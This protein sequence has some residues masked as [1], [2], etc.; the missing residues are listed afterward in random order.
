MKRIISALTLATFFLGVTALAVNSTN[1]T[2]KPSLDLEG[3]SSIKKAKEV[4]VKK[5][6]TGTTANVGYLN[7]FA[8]SNGLP[9]FKDENGMET[10]L[11]AGMGSQWVGSIDYGYAANCD[12]NSTSASFVDFSE[13]TDCNTPTVTGSVSAPGTKI[14]AVVVPVD[15]V[16][17]RYVF[18]AR[19]QFRTGGGTDAC[20]YRF[21]DGTDSSL[22]QLGDPGA[23][24]G[25]I[26]ESGITFS[27]KGSKTVKI[28]AKSEGAADSCR[29]QSTLAAR[30]FS[31]DV[32]KMGGTGSAGAILNEWQDISGVTFT[33]LG[34]V[35]GTVVKGR[36]VGDSLELVGYTVA[37]TVSGSTFSINLPSA[38]PIDTAKAGSSTLHLGTAVT[39]SGSAGFYANAGWAAALFSD[40]S[41][42]DSIFA[43][44]R[45]SG[46]TYEK[47]TGTTF[48]QSGAGMSF[49]VTIPISGWTGGFTGGGVGSAKAYTVSIRGGGSN[50]TKGTV[51][52]DTAWYQCVGN[53]L[54]AHWDYRQTAGGTAGS[55]DYFFS[56]PSGYTLNTSLQTAGTAANAPQ[57]RVGEF[58][59]FAGT[60]AAIGYVYISSSNDLGAV[61]YGDSWAAYN[62][63]SANTPLSTSTVSFTF[64]AKIPVNEC[65]N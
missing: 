18:V 26:I 41:D 62:V 38:Y 24:R 13:D 45:G 60:S 50:P 39:V 63:G 49:H 33:G 7:V 28:Q 30:E 48:G 6:A 3:S 54:H 14:P 12:W 21:S 17:A 37:G 9:Y 31:I 5:L 51:A 10:P 43:A 27:S 22:Q 57:G 58:S 53:V 16:G 4:E 8:K 15:D 25:T 34:T 65:N 23:N 55:G 46:S 36:R 11:V 44:Y 40:G 32:Y 64:D 20:A 35:S 1:R 19:G 29:I 61:Y 52:K 56:L 47:M 59:M 2:I 42:T